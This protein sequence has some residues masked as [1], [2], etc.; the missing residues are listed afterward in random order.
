MNRRRFTITLT[1]KQLIA[2]TTC[3]YEYYSGRAATTYLGWPV[4]YLEKVRSSI[5]SQF[6]SQLKERA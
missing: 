2:I 1:H 3:L 6:F 5:F 4:K